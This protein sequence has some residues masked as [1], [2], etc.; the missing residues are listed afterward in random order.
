MNQEHRTNVQ[1]IE[2]RK[3]KQ[4]N[5]KLKIKDIYKCINYNLV[6]KNVFSFKMNEK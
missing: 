2:W 4:Q 1:V 6:C 3:L 5:M